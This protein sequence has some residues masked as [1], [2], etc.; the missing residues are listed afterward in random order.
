MS[1]CALNLLFSV[2]N[3]CLTTVELIQLETYTDKV[4]LSPRKK[5]QEFA[6]GID[7]AN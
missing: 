3:N 4:Q 1:R 5:L 2:V 6:F 7:L